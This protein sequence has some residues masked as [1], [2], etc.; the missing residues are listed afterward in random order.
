MRKE[1]IGFIR[2]NQQKKSL[3][4]YE[5]KSTNNKI[6][7]NANISRLPK[8]KKELLKKELEDIIKKYI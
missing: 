6:T 7:F 3:S 1:L 4:L 8:E 2:E 5:F